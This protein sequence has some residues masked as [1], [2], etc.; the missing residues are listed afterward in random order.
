VNVTLFIDVYLLSYIFIGVARS[1]NISM[2]CL[3]FILSK[4]YCLLYTYF[5]N[6]NKNQD[7]EKFLFIYIS[8]IFL[9]LRLK[10]LNK[11]RFKFK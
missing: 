11:Y 10:N 1:L 7:D 5:A 8:D 3:I 2:H 9:L 4:R 6:K